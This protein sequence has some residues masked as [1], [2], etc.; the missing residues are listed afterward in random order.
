LKSDLGLDSDI[1]EGPRGKFSVLVD[2]KVVA[3]K[4]ADF[5]TDDAIVAA[6]RKAIA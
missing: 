4:G 3:E 5:P 6:V 2:G 1:V